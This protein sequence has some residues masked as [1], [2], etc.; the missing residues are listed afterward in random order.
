MG[1]FKFYKAKLGT[2]FFVHYNGALRE[3]ILIGYDFTIYGASTDI[4]V[5][6]GK[7]MPCV[8]L[9]WDDYLYS[10]IEKALAPKK[11]TTNL[12]SEMLI[13]STSE[14]FT[15]TF[16]KGQGVVYRSIGSSII[17]YIWDGSR[18][19]CFSPRENVTKISVR[20]VDGVMV[21]KFIGYY[22]DEIKFDT[23]KWYQSEEECIK[24]HTPKIV[25]LD[26]EPQNDEICEFNITIRC[27]KQHKAEILRSIDVIAVIEEINE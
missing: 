20:L 13:T 23:N 19:N 15:R 22:G 26:E 1:N 12:G 18:A 3:C 21:T 4:F 17:G 2:H 5:Y 27:M 7:D 14:E 24:A 6:M 8:K 9:H 25:M 11:G 16:L 10:S